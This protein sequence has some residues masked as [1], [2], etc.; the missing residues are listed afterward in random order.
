MHSDAVSVIEK[1]K[2][3]RKVGRELAYK[4]LEA[5]VTKDMLNHSSKLLGINVQGNELFFDS[6]EETSLLMDFVLFDYKVNGKNVIQLYL[7]KQPNQNKV[8]SEL[9]G[10]MLSAYTSF[11]EVAA[12][13]DYTVYLKDLFCRTDKHIELID[14]GFSAT[15]TPGALT[16]F[17]LVPV[18]SCNM[19][20]GVSFVFRNELKEYLVRRYP[21]ISKK[22]E[23]GDDNMK[24]YISFFKLNKECGEEI[25]HIG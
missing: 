4:I 23:T 22:I 1:Y 19:T 12:T 16:F 2:N 3:I 9:I 8:E 6:E 5:C 14:I 21:K 7:E 15:A 18:P 17:R 11:F 25:S 10:A 24:R 20:S 13:T